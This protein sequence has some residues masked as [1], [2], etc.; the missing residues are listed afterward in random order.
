M[1]L[2]M[3]GLLLLL[4]QRRGWRHLFTELLL[5]CL[6][7]IHEVLPA[8]NMPLLSHRV[9]VCPVGHVYECWHRSDSHS[10]RILHMF[11]VLLQ[12]CNMA[13]GSIVRLAALLQLQLGNLSANAAGLRLQGRH[14]AAVVLYLLRFRLG[15]VC[16]SIL[17]LLRC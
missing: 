2:L 15:H 7:R 4:R 8:G 13:I 5:M 16:K 1:Q 6:E 9:C 14:L 11:S 17:L 3:R 12:F 10:A